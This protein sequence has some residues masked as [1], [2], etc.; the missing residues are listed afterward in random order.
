M[1]THSALL[2]M[3]GW[4]HPIFKVTIPLVKNWLQII[5]THTVK[6]S[7]LNVMMDHYK[8]KGGVTHWRR[9][10]LPWAALTLTLQRIG[11]RIESPT[12]WVDHHLR[13]REVNVEAP[14]DVLA[15]V[16]EAC[17]QWV[18]KKVV[19]HSGHVE[20]EVWWEPLRMVIE[21]SEEKVGKGLVARKHWKGCR[22]S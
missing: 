19:G 18:L 1:S 6:F 16:K 3:P 15:T 13:S 11:W 2:C 4:T 17:I 22:N 12:I 14:R 7:D 8:S 9:G 20:K 21:T 5:W 10:K